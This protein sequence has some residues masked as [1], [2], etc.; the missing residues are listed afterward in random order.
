MVFG[1]NG[2]PNLCVKLQPIEPTPCNVLNCKVCESGSSTSCKACENGYILSFN[3]SGNQ[4]CKKVDLKPI[5]PIDIGCTSSFPHSCG[6]GV[7]C[8]ANVSCAAANSGPGY[9]CI[10]T[11]TSNRPAI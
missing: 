3:P 4:T 1:F 9:M 8:P 11:A 6:N 7:C 5:D 2:N 10:T